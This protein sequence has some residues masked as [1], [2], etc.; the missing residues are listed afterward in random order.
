MKKQNNNNM[1]PL[2]QH[3]SEY[4]IIRKDLYLVLGLNALYLILII[5][6]YLTNQ[7]THFLDAL[8]AKLI[9]F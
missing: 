5:A 2:V 3:Q 6:L 1:D 9:H 4:A 8:G 7:S